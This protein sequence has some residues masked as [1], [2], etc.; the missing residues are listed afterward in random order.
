MLS[1][2]ESWK[3]TIERFTQFPEYREL[4]SVD[5][6]P[7]VLEWKNFPG[8]HTAVSSR[9]PKT[10]RTKSIGDKEEI[11]RKCSASSS[12]VAAHA[13][14]FPR[15]GALTHKPNGSWIN[16][17]EL[18]MISVRESG[19]PV[20]RG[21]Q[22][23]SSEELFKNNRGGR[24]SVHKK[25]GASDCRPVTAHHYLRQ[26]AQCLRSSSGLVPRSCSAN[27]SSFLLQHRKSCC[28]SEQ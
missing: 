9:S 21:K 18:M 16:V 20:F 5:G 8:H 15:H 7:V 23:L 6:K 2:H 12:N 27:R 14:N 13:A 22:V 17:A 3:D 28:K 24:T 11:K 25:S 10:R 1:A 4:D 26:S 19:H